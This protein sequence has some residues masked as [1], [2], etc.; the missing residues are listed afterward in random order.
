MSH[1]NPRY[2]NATGTRLAA[3]GLIPCTALLALTL[4]GAPLQGQG[5]VN[6]V[7]VGTSWPTPYRL[8]CPANMLVIGIRNWGSM[9]CSFFKADGSRFGPA[10]A[11]TTPS[12]PSNPAS[13]FLD[14]LMGRQPPA[15]YP[16][17]S[18]AG[19]G[20]VSAFRA[21]VRNDGDVDAI[22]VYCAGIGPGGGQTGSQ[23]AGSL[24]AGSSVVAN[25]TAACPGT[26]FAQG[27]LLVNGGMALACID[28]P[29]M[30]NNVSH[31]ALSTFATTGGTNVLGT[32]ILNGVAI[33]PVTVGLAVTD[34]SGAGVPPS[35]TIRDGA[36][37]AT[38][39]VH[40]G[41]GS[42]GCGTVRATFGTTTVSAPLTV[43][44][45]Q[46]AG[47]F[48]FVVQPASSS[49]TWGAPSSIT[50]IVTYSS[51]TPRVEFAS[52]RPDVLSIPTAP[53]SP[54]TPLSI[55]Q[56]ATRNSVQVTMNALRS[57]CAIVTATVD[58]VAARR[59]LRIQ[60]GL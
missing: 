13:G 55:Q 45:M 30:A 4:V 7:S 11:Q 35:V 3:L 6:T 15:S 56:R 41:P 28:A 49:L 33:G 8:M 47:L 29:V 22:D 50:A 42:A 16:T 57:G 9:D 53:T 43:S 10:S 40:T 60:T 20:A 36:R 21:H 12:P 46:P 14:F 34:V 32:V 58:G 19:N 26:R 5:G 27:L 48:S 59:T 54:I 31:V 51:G 24:P 37:D 17:V 2:F 39:V 25:A 52:D 23:R 38:F 18:C 1:A 44:P